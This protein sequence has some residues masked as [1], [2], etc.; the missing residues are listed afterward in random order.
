MNEIETGFWE[1]I[2][3]FIAAERTIEL[4]EIKNVVEKVFKSDIS[5]HTLLGKKL[6]T[7]H[8]VLRVIMER[9]FSRFSFL[10]FFAPQQ[11]ISKYTLDFFICLDSRFELYYAIEIDGHDFH[12]KTKEQAEKDKRRDRDML[13]LNIKTIRF[14]GSEIFIK[15]QKCIENILNIICSDVARELGKWL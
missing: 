9:R 5:I 12:E 10:I 8:L 11:R 13:E 14:T 2:T 4:K 6:E 15:P 3:K 7:E 1:E